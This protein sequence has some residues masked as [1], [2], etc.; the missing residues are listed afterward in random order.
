MLVRWIGF[1]QT[2]LNLGWSLQ[3]AL[4]FK[5]CKNWTINK[6][7]NKGNVNTSLPLGVYPEN[8]KIYLTFSKI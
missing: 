5:Q 1:W 6:I 3:M 8:F 4:A 2:E 7:G